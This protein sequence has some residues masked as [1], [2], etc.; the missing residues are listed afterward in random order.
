[1]A[2][3][4]M[5]PE[6]IEKIVI[7]NTAAFLLPGDKP[8]PRALWLGRHSALGD[9]LIRKFNIFS[10]ISSWTSCTQNKMPRALRRAYRLPYNNWENRI[11]T[12]RFVQD[13]PLTPED[14]SYARLKE[15][16]DNL[17]KLKDVP[18]LIC[19]GEKDF[20]FDLDFLAEWERRFPDAE[21]H[22]YPKAGHYI[23]EDAAHELVPL[24]GN[25]IRGAQ[26]V[27]G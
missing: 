8:L 17:H 12:A 24:I 4:T 10:F 19:W 5:Y 26:N 20:V 23:L 25:F 22:R 1:M 15:V 11:A 2:Y 9:Y 7:L 21:V 3:A 14:A 18:K 6:K 16:E 13:I 27:T